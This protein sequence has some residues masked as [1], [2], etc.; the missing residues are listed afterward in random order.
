M[1][2]SLTSPWFIESSL[3]LQTSIY[4]FVRYCTNLSEEL[5]WWMTFQQEWYRG[6]WYAA[7]ILQ[8]LPM[9]YSSQN[10]I[11]NLDSNIDILFNLL[12]KWFFD[13]TPYM[14]WY[15]YSLC[16]KL[17]KFS[18]TDFGSQFQESLKKWFD[19]QESIKL[20]E[21]PKSEQI[22]IE[23]KHKLHES[24]KWFSVFIDILRKVSPDPWILYEWKSSQLNPLFKRRIL[25]YNK[26]VEQYKSWELQKLWENKKIHSRWN[27]GKTKE[28]IKAF[29][30]NLLQLP[31]WE[32]LL[33]FWIHTMKNWEFDGIDDQ[34]EIYTSLWIFAANFDSHYVAEVSDY[35]Q[36]L[37]SSEN[38]SWFQENLSMNLWEL[39]DWVRDGHLGTHS[40]NL[41]IALEFLELEWIR[42][43][44]D[45]IWNPDEKEKTFM[46]FSYL[47]R[48]ELIQEISLK[49]WLL[50]LCLEYFKI[51]NQVEESILLEFWRANQNDWILHTLQESADTLLW[52]FDS[53]YEFLKIIYKNTQDLYIFIEGNLILN[54]KY[55][56]YSSDIDRLAT[57]IHSLTQK[58]LE[59]KHIIGNYPYFDLISWYLEDM[60]DTILN[61][62]NIIEKVCLIWSHLLVSWEF[63]SYSH[64]KEV[65]ALLLQISYRSSAWYKDVIS[66]YVFWDES[67]EF[68]W[69]LNGHIYNLLDLTDDSQDKDDFEVIASHIDIF[70]IFL[71]THW[72]LI[73]DEILGVEEAQELLHKILAYVLL[74]WIIK[75]KNFIS[76]I[77][78]KCVMY[79]Q[80]S[81]CDTE[82]LVLDFMMR[83]K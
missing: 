30:R 1:K 13:D 42:V 23:I 37:D 36:E 25:T 51:H 83:N 18:E 63:E 71:E 9:T 10:N 75:D 29:Y 49:D 24:L 46:L 39:I 62:E 7:I 16:K 81:N 55:E 57:A 61:E 17:C 77:G 73:P 50:V 19:V 31:I 43:P 80:D 47:L 52:Y 26:L 65:Q 28:W 82:K 20:L 41:E 5:E 11:I 14:F 34:F 4:K 22:Q 70:L 58:S 56:W 78:Q 53:Y 48:S 76:E 45:I 64:G 21:P 27:S 15:V 35:V 8:A 69:D 38:F 3:E 74:A 33:Q 40:D 44:E 32:Q 2:D 12:E 59:Q 6:A 66:N 68:Q 72:T 54:P 67:D 79:F 60:N